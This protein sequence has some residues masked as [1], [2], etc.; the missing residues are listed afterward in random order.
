MLVFGLIGYG[1]LLVTG[2]PYLQLLPLA[3]GG[4]AG[5]WVWRGC[6]PACSNSAG[7]LF[8]LAAIAAGFLASAFVLWIGY[9]IVLPFHNED[10]NA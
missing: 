5:A 9:L 1:K 4:A 7:E 2:N 6:T 10:G 8:V 3:F